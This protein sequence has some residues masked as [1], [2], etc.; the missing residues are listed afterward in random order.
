MRLIICLCT[1]CF[2][3]DGLLGCSK[4]KRTLPQNDEVIVYDPVTLPKSN[5]T[6]IFVHYMTWFETKESSANNTWGMHWTMS[7][8]NPDIIDGDGKREIASYFY[9]QIGPYHSGDKDV[10][11]YHLLLMKYAGLDGVLF[12]WYGTYDV[13]DY[14]II[15]DNTQAVIDLIDKVGLKFSIVYEDRTLSEVVSCGMAASN[16]SA[17]KTDM[18]FLQSNFFNSP[19]YVYIDNH[20]LLMVFGPITL[21]TPQAWTNVFNI[22]DSKPMFLTLWNESAD[23]GDNAHG[24]YAWVYM[25]N[26]YLD[27]FYN[28]RATGLGVVM[29]SAYPGFIDFYQEGGWGDGIG[30]TIDH[31]NG[32][33]LDATLQKAGVADVDYLQL[34][35]W[36]DFG[37]GTIIEPTQQFGYTYLDKIKQFAGV[38]SNESVFEQ[39][40]HLFLLRKEFKSD[41]NAQKHLDQIFYYFVSLQV[42]KAV[43]EL[44]SFEPVL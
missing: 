2:F 23:A 16:E 20:P 41:L 39:I 7:N 27:N 25:N 30:W 1:A 6:E 4:E 15:N 42:D 40:H 14:Q 9:P 11:E 44:Q 43:E 21:Q 31:N 5:N 8:M 34:V 38:T 32:A 19:S 22:L 17:A 13:N 33:T 26:S 3:L 28:D 24:E 37:E 18:R 10:I 35:T 29:G 36:N 12:D